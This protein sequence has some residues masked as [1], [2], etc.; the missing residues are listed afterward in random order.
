MMLVL[1][2]INDVYFISDQIKKINKNFELFFNKKTSLYEVRNKNNY[3]LVITYKN[4][5]DYGLIEKLYKT[6]KE[7][8]KNLFIEIEK[9]NE[10][11]NN[12]KTKD[13][14]DRSSNQISMIFNYL[15]SQPSK[16]LTSN[17]IK[18]IIEKEDKLWRKIY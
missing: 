12:K 8:M 10:K 4:Y 18:N 7:N 15:V 6:N 14:I 5:P 16:D 2:K 11:I 13:L 3:E 1:E 17:Q 9:E